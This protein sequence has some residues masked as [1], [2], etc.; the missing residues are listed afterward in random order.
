MNRRIA[1]LVTLFVI[2][3]VPAAEPKF[4]IHPGE[5]VLFLGDSITEQYQ[6]STYI[7]LYLTTRFP[8]DKLEF[9]NAG[10]GGDTSTGG[11][12]RFATHVLAEKPAIVTIDFGMNDGGYGSFTQQRCDQ[13][14]KS[15]EQMLE[16]AKKAG[17]RVVL[18]SPNAVEVRSK[19]NLKTYLE[20]QEKF[21]APLKELAA[22][23]DVP[24]VDQYAVTRKVLDKIAAD[25]AKVKPF[26]DGVHTGQAGGLLMAHTILVGMHAPAEV[27]QY[28]FEKASSVGDGLS[29]E[30]LDD[31]IPMPLLKEWRDLLP[32]VNQLKDLNR[33]KLIAKG[34]KPGKYEL[35]IDGQAV[36]TYTAEELADGVNVAIAG[37]GPL[38]DQGMKVLDAINKKNDIVHKRFRSV[39]MFDPKTVPD[40]VVGSNGSVEQKRRD[41]LA[42]L[43]AQIAEKQAEVYKLATPVKHKWE[44]KRAE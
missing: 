41:E 36:A 26:G 42:R 5:R 3:S 30:R 24:F 18:I 37:K 33:Y 38:Q 16:A 1:A 14:L 2:Q 35:T 27:S 20:T 34:L 31:A 43:D 28:K 19:P 44:L 15:T 22:K 4:P 32:Y 25:D 8:K 6:Y 40:W 7:E 29:F 11:A 39:V 17:V 9:Y 13:Y 10:I 23:Y 21:Y 12:R